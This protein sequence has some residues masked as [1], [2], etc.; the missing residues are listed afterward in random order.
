MKRITE[1]DGRTSPVKRRTPA[2]ERQA[3][4]SKR[5]KTCGPRTEED[6]TRIFAKLTFLHL[7]SAG[8]SKKSLLLVTALATL[9]G[10]ARLYSQELPKRGPFWIPTSFSADLSGDVMWDFGRRAGMNEMRLGS[11]FRF[12][13]NLSVCAVAKSRRDADSTS[14]FWGKRD[15]R[16]AEAYLRY[17]AKLPVPPYGL[18][19]IVKA[20]KLERY[21]RFSDIELVMENWDAY[22]HPVRFYGA[23]LSLDMPLVR[24]GWLNAHADGISGDL[25]SSRPEPHLYNAFLRLTPDLFVKDLGL[26][27]QVGLNEGTDDLVS[28]A[29]VRYSPTVFRDLKVD[30]RAGRLPGRD[31]TP[32]GARIS[33]WKPFKYIALGAYYERR[34]NQPAETQYLG[35]S[36][37]IIGPPWLARFMNTFLI[38]YD[39]N[40]NTLWAHIPFVEVDIR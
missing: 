17:S 23:D 32:F 11:E 14:S 16:L 8:V 37:R 3:T 31:E 38:C 19:A 13:G 1:R 27:A 20:G 18:R 10:F 4:V 12:P 7:C 22:L 39:T 15:L 5:Q 26:T 30:L 9:A 21:P 33:A 36:W 6:E 35:F 25:A 2:A 24:S 40:N 28:E 34:L 29:V